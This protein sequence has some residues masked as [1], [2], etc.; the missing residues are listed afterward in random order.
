MSSNILVSHPYLSTD[1]NMQL[2]RAFKEKLFL[3]NEF[4]NVE[5]PVIQITKQNSHFLST[6]PPLYSFARAQ[7]YHYSHK[8]PL[9]QHDI[10][11]LYR[12]MPN[13]VAQSKRLR[14]LNPSYDI[15][16][17]CLEL[18]QFWKGYILENEKKY[19]INYPTICFTKFPIS[20]VWQQGGYILFQVVLT[21]TTQVASATT[22]R[23]LNL[24]HDT[25]TLYKYMKN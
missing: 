16:I 19:L 10:K 1:L 24:Q 6:E 20:I 7:R 5:D 22:L 17:L 4:G 13:A 18:Y 9:S 14:L 25:L 12:I 3:I 11:Y 23:F 21:F 8:Y 2:Y 15:Y